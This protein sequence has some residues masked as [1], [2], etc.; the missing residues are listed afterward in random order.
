MT[1]VPAA[2]VADPFLLRAH[3]RWHMFFEVYN[4]RANKGEIGLATS[5]DGL[6]WAYRRIVLAEEF[7]LSYP[8]VFEWAGER[9]LVPESFQ[10]GSVRLYRAD[11]F[12][13]RW[14]LAAT[15]LEGPYLVDASPWPAVGSV[16]AFEILAISVVFIVCTD[17]SGFRHLARECG[18]RPGNPQAF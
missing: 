15:L 7:H 14:T 18:D 5:E 16:S 9:W 13:E 2:Y 12:P 6:R 11:P 1:D 10:S 4:W 8:Y 17:S 3:G